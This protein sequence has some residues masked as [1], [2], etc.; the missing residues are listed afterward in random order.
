MPLRDVTT[1]ASPPCRNGRSGFTLV[2][3]AGT[4]V[5]VSILALVAVPRFFNNNAFDVER[6]HAQAQ[7]V[8]RHAQKTAI[9]Q[10][11]NVFVSLDGARFAACFDAACTAYVVTPAG[12]NSDSA[13][14][15]DNCSDNDTALCEAIPS[16]I[17]FNKSIA[18][19]GFYF[20]AL[21]K[22]FH[23]TDP[24]PTP[25]STFVNALVITL[26][27]EGD[28][29]QLVVEPETGYVHQ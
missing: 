8:L 7:S 29:R 11:R 18:G 2:E 3:L 12:K 25:T 26:S 5:I 22:P 27:K 19:A 14:T 23:L 17:A 6:F 10:N 28:T 20:N 9:A 21:G 24:P 1:H 16:G 4:L 13:R 15:Q